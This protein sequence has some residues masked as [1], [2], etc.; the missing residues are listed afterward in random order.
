MKQII[1]CFFLSFG[2]WFWVTGQNTISIANQTVTPDQTF[3]VEVMVSNADPFVA[4][5]MDLPIPSGLTI[6]LT[7]VTLNPARSNG[8]DIDA[9][10]LGVSILRVICFSIDN[11]SFTGSSGW[12]FRFQLT[13]GKVP[14]NYILLPQNVVMGNDAGVNLP[15]AI[16][17]GTILLSAPNISLDQSS[18][19][20]GNTAVS[21]QTVRTLI[22]SNT[23]TQT[24]SVTSIINPDSQF[25]ISPAAPLSIDAGS[26]QPLNITFTPTWKGDFTLEF[27][28]HSSDPDQP[29]V[30]VQIHAKAYTINEIH[31]GSLSVFSGT[32]GELYLTV[33]NME[34]FTA[35]Q[36]DLLL[37]SAMTPVADSVWFTGRFSNHEIVASQV[38]PNRLRVVGF[39]PD[40]T[41][42]SGSS[43][44]LIRIGFQVEG[45]GGYYGIGIENGIIG[46]Q[47]GI[48]ILS[49]VYGGSLQIAAPDIQC[50]AM[51]DFGEVASIG[52]KIMELPVY[53]S[54]NDQ[55]ILSEKDTNNVAFSVLTAFPVTILPGETRNI[56]LLYLSPMEGIHTGRLRL[57]SNDPDENPWSVTL[58]GSSFIPNRVYLPN[59]SYTIGDEVILDVAVRNYEPFVALQFDLVFSKDSF[60]INVDN[61]ALSARLSDHEVVGMELHP[62][63]VRVLAWSLAQTPALGADGTIL[64]IPIGLI[65]EKAGTYRFE[66]ENVVLGN[67][68]AE[69]IIRDAAGGILTLLAP[70][71]TSHKPMNKGWTWFSLNVEPASWNISDVLQSIVPSENDYIKNQTASATYYAGYG[72]FG[73]LETL[74]PKEFYKIKLGNAA[75]LIVTGA[76]ANPADYPI[77]LVTGWNWV[78]Y[79]PQTAQA[80]NT[81]FTGYP[82]TGNDY[83]KNQ[84][85]STAWYPGFGWFG[86]LEQLSP[87]DGYML[88]IGQAGVLTYQIAL[89]L[90][91]KKTI[92][93][94]IKNNP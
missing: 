19:D 47:N 24:L 3:W 91:Q 79:I 86:D 57:F 33:N 87:L 18:I 54:G 10:M 70:A 45:T 28:V 12:L 35:V 38:G 93:T 23:G 55:L 53:N 82:L 2:S 68:S 26:S 84:T 30:K 80:V 62:G 6:D 25:A 37:P 74:N 90:M 9:S 11:V 14:G 44:N 48:N 67:A 75:E 58:S 63:K 4:L 46:D 77:N 13:A 31:A 40:N 50:S 81:I 8:H 36:F 73:E 61:I 66:L 59:Q 49:A 22:I 27:T 7:T 88:K 29:A 15:S 69:N 17:Q 89:W 60:S 16:T 76:A 72:W 1:L 42:F 41:A 32:Y 78:G 56:E 64:R 92:V 51:L 5:Q 21:Q 52:S 20:F 85:I 94:E 71:S 39:S 34:P 43:G 83:L 65:V